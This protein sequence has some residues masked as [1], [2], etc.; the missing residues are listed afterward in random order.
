MWLNCKVPKTKVSFIGL[1]SLAVLKA[2]LHNL[3][4]LEEIFSVLVILNE[5]LEA[6]TSVAIHRPSDTNDKS[7]FLFF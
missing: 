7:D 5:D 6:R 2:Q 3:Y 4:T 1:S